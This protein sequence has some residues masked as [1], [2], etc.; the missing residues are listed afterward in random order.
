MDVQCLVQ[1]FQQR[2]NESILLWFR[3]CPFKS[4]TLYHTFLSVKYGEIPCNLE[5]QASKLKV[6]LQEWF[7]NLWL[8]LPRKDCWDTVPNV[9]KI[10]SER[11]VI[12]G[13]WIDGVQVYPG[14]IS[15]Y[16]RPFLEEWD[17]QLS[18]WHESTICIFWSL[19]LEEGLYWVFQVIF[20]S[21]TYLRRRRT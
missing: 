12:S 2:K 15:P 17:W 14:W 11:H 16:C 7:I 18:I 21:S 10:S 6:P 4:D 20:Q 8:W 1:F 9:C 5:S 13:V 19:I 3:K